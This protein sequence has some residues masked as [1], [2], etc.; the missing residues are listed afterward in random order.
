MALLANPTLEQLRLIKTQNLDMLFALARIEGPVT[1]IL[2]QAVGIG[3][4]SSTTAFDVTRSA[5]P[6]SN[7]LQFLATR[8]AAT[9]PNGKPSRGL[10]AAQSNR[11]SGG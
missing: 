9:R 2:V 4:K 6:R 11:T 1:T 3:P 7:E 10:R 8:A 5:A